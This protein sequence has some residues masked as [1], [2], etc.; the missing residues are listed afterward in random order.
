MVRWVIAGS[1]RVS[2]GAFGSIPYLDMLRLVG[3][4]VDRLWMPDYE[5]PQGRNHAV[6]V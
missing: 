3:K 1:G 5:T 6:Q 4:M 2:G